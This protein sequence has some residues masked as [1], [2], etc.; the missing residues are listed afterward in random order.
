MSFST[1]SLDS[2]SGGCDDTTCSPAVAI[3]LNF[4]IITLPG[5]PWCAKAKDLLQS[6]NQP[7]REY[8]VVSETEARQLER[9]DLLYP[10]EHKT[11]PVVFSS[12]KEFLG[13]YAELSQTTFGQ[14]TFSIE[15]HVSTRDA[16]AIR[17]ILDV[18]GPIYFPWCSFAEGPLSKSSSHVHFKVLASKAMMLDMQQTMGVPE[19]ETR[20]YETF[21]VT[22]FQT[23]PRMIYLNVDNLRNTTGRT[24][25]FK[26][27]L[28]YYCYVTLHELGHALGFVHHNNDTYTTRLKMDEAP[29][30]HRLR[31]CRVMTQQTERRF[32]GQCELMCSEQVMPH[33]CECDAQRLLAL[34]DVLQ[35]PLEGGRGRMRRSTTRRVGRSMNRTATPVAESHSTIKAGRN[36]MSTYS[37]SRWFDDG[38]DVPESTVM[39]ARGSAVSAEAGSETLM[40]G[41]STAFDGTT[42][43][44]DPTSVMDVHHP[45]L[46]AGTQLDTTITSDVQER[47]E[48][49]SVLSGGGTTAD[50]TA[51]ETDESSVSKSTTQTGSSSSFSAGEE[52]YQSSFVPAGGEDDEKYEEDSSGEDASGT[53]TEA[54]TGT[55]TDSETDSET[56]TGTD[57]GTETEA[58]TGTEYKDLDSFGGGAA[59]GFMSDSLASSAPPSASEAL[60]LTQSISMLTSLRDTANDA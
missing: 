56:G 46:L 39:D 19:E 11:F 35:T 28:W 9:K 43:D 51:T 47:F 54:E 10:K 32:Q 3:P 49:S 18:L 25:H 12:M 7:Y 17:T 55:G 8:E 2:L 33:L 52:L 45:S 1:T 42:I 58:E 13:G 23:S 29:E 40:I 15:K 26:K 59:K 57:S 44:G 36:T 37:Y 14:V 48:P 31:P 60:D 38:S 41:G 5:C 4:H 24:A 6:K 22:F 20:A 16:E 34:G 21:S 53:G 30:G 50:D 27:R